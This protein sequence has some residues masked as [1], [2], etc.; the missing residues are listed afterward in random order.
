[1]KTDTVH[2][3]DE[4]ARSAF[5]LFGQRGI[6]HVTLDE[7][8]ANAGVTKGALYW[9]Y[10]SKKELILAAAALYYREWQQQCHDVI[11]QADDP[12]DQI[13]RVWEASV[14]MCL[15]DRGK[16]RFSTEIFAL[17]LED[18]E[19]RAS[20]AQFYDTVRE[21]F[22]SLIRAASRAGQLH[23][24]DPRWM[25]D[26]LL[27][28]FEGIKHRASFEPQICTRQERDRMVDGLMQILVLMGREALD[29]ASR[30]G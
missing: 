3:R 25:A 6:N 19:I 21:L 11:A 1:M 15:F 23:V 16:R 14:S 7:V 29:G 22:V 8:A 12:L 10:N 27:A 18:P 4:L 5:E 30:G 13:R 24:D 9:H 26:W 28:Q 2:I 20:W 17:G